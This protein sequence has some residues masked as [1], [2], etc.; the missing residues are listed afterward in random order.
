[1]LNTDR[2]CLG[3]MN[4]CG[5]EKVCGI[6]GYDSDSRNDFDCLPAKLWLRDRYLI[7]KV[8][9]RDTDGVV[10]IGW[11]NARD[12]IV[13]IREFF[14]SFALRNP[15]KTISVSEE[16]KYLFNGG[17]L[18][19]LEINKK[20]SETELP[21]LIPTV[22]VFEEN[23]T[24][25]VVN[26]T[27]SGI[28]LEDFLN[29]N[30]GTLKWEQARPL[31]LP[32]MDTLKGL[33]EM[34]ITHGGISPKTILV[35]RDGKLRI[36]AV[37]I[38]NSESADNTQNIVNPG[39]SAIEQYN[40][41]YGTI[42]YSTDVYSLSAT[43]FCVLIGNVP[44]A[45]DLRLENDNMTIPAKFAEELPRNVLVAL[46]NGLQ[47]LPSNR[48]SSI[49]NFRNELVYG[50]SADGTDINTA[51]KKRAQSE[52]ET[53]KSPKS[54]SGVKAAVISAVCTALVF[55][56]I[57]GVLSLTLFKDYIFPKDN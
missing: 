4:D 41:S 36:S 31:F 8:L 44:P 1:M 26:A 12:S 53:K 55:V 47:V 22:D 13:N 34:E 48:T 52:P 38:N 49:N 27:F 50:D 18:R 3:C 35:G 37:K 45:A 46:A 42:T 40:E 57:A 15:D 19:F 30:G 24:G 56:I 14:P 2:L 17:L 7:G 29:R 10:Y 39:F 11:D 25:Y 20:L 16:S 6:C 43:L 33:H 23:G 54:G 9:S 51:H 32:L 5:G 28:T 21:S